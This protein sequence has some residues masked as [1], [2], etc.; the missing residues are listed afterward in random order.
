MRLRDLA[1]EI[2]LLLFA[3]GRAMLRA[4]SLMMKP[5]PILLV[6][7]DASHA[8]L[9][10]RALSRSILANEVVVARDGAEAL[11]YLFATGPHAGRDPKRQPSVVLL[12]LKLPKVS[13]ADVLRRMR[14]D[15]RTRR[16]PVVIL[17]SS[18]SEQDITFTCKLGANGYVT[19][20]ADSA[21]FSEAV[22]RLG[23]CWMRGGKTPPEERA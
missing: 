18:D 15:E 3:P 23:D 20:S 9:T 10:L 8:A 6:E 12:D 1:L 17:T 22:A 19:K 5:E 16:V 11:D 14:A 4:Q 7:D 13:G 2:W 21:K